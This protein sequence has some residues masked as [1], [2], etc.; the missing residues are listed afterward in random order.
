M[1]GGAAGWQGEGWLSTVVGAVVQCTLADAVAVQHA[2]GLPCVSC[3]VSHQ[4]VE[5]LVVL[6]TCLLVLICEE[7]LLPQQQCHMCCHVYRLQVLHQQLPGV[8]LALTQA[9][10]SADG[11]AAAAAAVDVDVLIASAAAARQ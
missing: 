9:G 2:F 3:R 8:T 6:G 5:M 11:A 1:C 7:E 4:A 10:L